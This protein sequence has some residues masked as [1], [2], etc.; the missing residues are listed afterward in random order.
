[1]IFGIGWFGRVWMMKVERKET[2]CGKVQ[3]ILPVRL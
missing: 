2:T 3:S 1:M